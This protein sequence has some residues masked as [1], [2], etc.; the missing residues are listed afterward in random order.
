[1]KIGVLIGYPTQFEGPFFQFAARDRKHDLRVIYSD[2]ERMETVFD[3]E[4]SR[5]ISWG[6]DLLSGYEYTVMPRAGRARWLREEMRRQRYDLL[7]VGGYRPYDFLLGALYARH[8]GTTTALRLDSVLFSFPSA[9]RRWARR[10]LFGSFAPLFQHYFATGSLSAAYLRYMGV[11]GE[12]ISLFPYVVDTARFREESRLRPM[13]QGVLR[14][15]YDLPE[16]GRVVLSVAKFNGREAPWDLLRAFCAA[17]RDGIS[18]LL[19]GDGEQRPALERYAAGYP[20]HAIRFAG[21]VPYPELPP[22]YGMADLFVHAA[23]RESWGVS[24]AEAMACGLPVIASSRVGAAHDL[25]APGRNGFT[26]AAGDAD[27]L[28][29]KIEQLLADLS[30]D[31]VRRENERILAGWDHAAT[32]NGIVATGQ[33]LTARAERGRL[34]EFGRALP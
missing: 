3:P 12:R 28:N 21:Y 14:R 11:A 27:E 22:L 20:R 4:L 10:A 5:G 1:M 13:E 17:E 25:I 8:Y 6:I 16:D 31:A 33:R 26:Y 30:P 23:D 2:A 24:V 7:I 29:R 15:R 18:L 9:R 19:V 34:G 32:W